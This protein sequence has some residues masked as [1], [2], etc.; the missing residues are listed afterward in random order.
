VLAALP[1]GAILGADLT[2]SSSPSSNPVEVGEELVSTIDRHA[3]SGT[4]RV[5]VR[6]TTHR[7][8]HLVLPIPVARY[9]DAAR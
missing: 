2:I 9:T 7:V 8:Q 1:A 6:E 4:R 3:F 5:S